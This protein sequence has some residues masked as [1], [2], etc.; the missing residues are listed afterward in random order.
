MLQ[1]TFASMTRRDEVRLLKSFAQNA[2][3]AKMVANFALRSRIT[4]AY[5]AQAN[6]LR[7]LQE[8]MRRFQTAKT[9]RTMLAWKSGF[10]LAKSRKAAKEIHDRT[11]KK[12]IREGKRQATLKL[13]EKFEDKFPPGDPWDW[14]EDQR[15]RA[16]RYKEET[17][18]KLAESLGVDV[19]RIK[20]KEGYDSFRKGSHL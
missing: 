14:S 7:K 5:Q 10:E 15:R 16:D 18:R 17:R 1:S 6:A 2:V 20:L 3:K 4:S 8:V 9:A 11:K 12:M 13:N 19:S